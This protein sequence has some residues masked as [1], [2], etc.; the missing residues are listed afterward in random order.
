[1][2]GD[3]LARLY[4]VLTPWER[5]PLLAAAAA[6]GDGAEVERL[7][8]SAP[9]ALFRVPDSWGLGTALERLA[10][11]AL[12][13]RLELVALYR[14]ADACLAEFPPR[15]RRGRGR[16]TE[17]RLGELA[18]WFARVF[19]VHTDAWRLLCGEL[20]FDPEALVRDQPGYETVRRFEAA[21]RAVAFTAE[22]ALD[23]LRGRMGEGEGPAP[24]GVTRV[25]RLDG[26][27]DVA[28]AWR[29]C[30]DEWAGWWA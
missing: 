4:G 8:R 2:R 27:E 30:L 5:V 28:R 22:E 15:P 7:A 11:Q 19:V 14:E 18:R 23:Y 25:W 6:R 10:Y 24:A 20:K 12:L 17:A 16:D 13:A 29:E 1:M 3:S 26:A 9:T 21:A